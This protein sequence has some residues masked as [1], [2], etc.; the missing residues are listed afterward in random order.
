VLRRRLANIFLIFV[1]VLAGASLHILFRAPRF[2][3]NILALLP[4]IYPDKTVEEALNAHSLA[5]SSKVVI[6]VRGTTPGDIESAAS[7]LA[8]GMRASGLFAEVRDRASLES[9]R[10]LER[11]FRAHPFQLT[12]P[13]TTGD[14]SADAQVLLDEARAH[15]FAPQGLQWLQGIGGDPLLRLPTYLQSIQRAEG[16]YTLRNGYVYLADSTQPTLLVTARLA[17][18]GLHDGTRRRISSFFEEYER[19]HGVEIVPGGIVFFAEEAASRTETEVSTITGV[20]MLLVTV[21]LWW[22]F[23]T[24]RMVLITSLA[25]VLSFLVTLVLSQWIWF[26]W[27]ETPLHLITLGFGSSLIG[28]S[29]DYALHYFVAHRLTRAD[30]THSPLRRVRSGLILGFVTTVIGFVGIAM[31]PFPGLQQLALFSICGL[32]ISLLIV[33][34]WLPR[35]SGPPLYDARLE[36]LVHSSQLLSSRRFYLLLGVMILTVCTI[37]LPRLVVRD[38]IRVL[39]TPSPA[40]LAR[41]GEV[42]RSTGTSDGGAFVLVYADDEEKL[43]QR[44]ERVR[45]LL[46]PLI[47]NGQ[48]ASY[49]ALSQVVPSRAKQNAWY[50]RTR[51]ILARNERAVAGFVEELHLPVISRER[52]SSLSAPTPPDFLTVAA[53]LSTGAC[54][55]VRDLYI[56]RAGAGVAS[57]VMVRGLRVGAES[58]FSG[59]DG[60]VPISQTDTI[61]AALKRYREVAMGYTASVY[62]IVVLLLVWR[63]GMRHAFWTLV[64]P[65]LGGA[66][67]LAVLALC[68][69]PINV[70][71]VFALLV[72]IGLSIDYAIF[73]AE[74]TL[75]ASGTNF[76]VLLSA[77][78]TAISFGL[79]SLSSTPALRSF[80]IVLSIGVLVAALVAP[81]AARSTVPC[82]T[83]SE[84]LSILVLL[85]L[86]TAGCSLSLPAPEVSQVRVSDATLFT[87]LCREVARSGQVLL[88][89]NEPRTAALEC[90]EKS[91]VVVVL[92]AFGLRTQTVVLHADG[93]VHSEVVFLASDA[94]E[95]EQLLR[96]FTE[97]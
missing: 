60:I 94:I 89:G 82:L 12:A 32:F 79:L 97:L 85:A 66:T 74:D 76:A 81:L 58:V 3:T 51:A 75:E 86:F 49:R 38:D 57:V 41:Q 91:A 14:E 48:L 47:T 44:E 96:K 50:Q 4:S 45:D 72:L 29:S 10:A 40:L 6:L 64:P 67:S 15:A 59:M 71:S 5:L 21:V 95:P 87:R 46:E 16:G 70:F 27:A 63:Y 37:G 61:S 30:A 90:S 19:P 69:V 13:P 42:A 83:R 31:S 23:R 92:N 77:V 56:G 33:F 7:T 80:G 28:V 84:R 55:L 9:L 78:T 43:L 65:T 73:C 25:L 36:R 68:G 93:A 62:V 17:T 22:I 18:S 35:L 52:L 39:S 2:E 88:P 11:Q 1:L 54:D 8:H 53:C 34:L 24:P 26:A 20:T